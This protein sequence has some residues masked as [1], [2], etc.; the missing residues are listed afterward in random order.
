MTTGEVRELFAYSAWANALVFDTA[1]A[2]STEQLGHS[3]ASSFPSI[4]ATLAHV[5]GAEWVWLRRWLGESPSGFPEWVKSPVLAELRTRLSGVERER[6]AF[7]ADLSDADLVRVVSYHTLGGQP[8]WDP[9]GGLMRHVVNH[10]TYH[11]G[12]VVTQLRQ[13]G[14]KPPTTDLIV[15]MRRSS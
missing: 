15:F 14:F 9:L 13:L 4:G 10:S 12:Q 11:R 3:V 1:A 5:V 7:V 2:L 6:E 8:F